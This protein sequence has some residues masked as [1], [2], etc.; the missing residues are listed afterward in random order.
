MKELKPIGEVV[1]KPMQIFYDLQ[2]GE[3]I[4]AE[5][6]ITKDEFFK[7]LDRASQPIE[8]PQSDQEQS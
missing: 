1:G 5:S 7:V 8:K 4:S 2:P 6:G 3:S